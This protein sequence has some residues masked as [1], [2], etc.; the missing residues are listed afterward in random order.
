MPQATDLTIKKANGTTDIVWTLMQPAS[1]D[2]SNAVWRS[3]TVGTSPAVRPMLSVTAK[4]AKSGARH[5]N[6][7]LSY[8]S[9]MQD[10]DG[11]QQIQG[12]NYFNFHASI[13]PSALDSDSAEMAAQAANLL[14]TTLLK[15]VVA[16]G[17]APT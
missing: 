17:F 7:T 4:A 16:A 3:N 13:A 11:I 14:A 12:V 10:A 8:P 2:D 15:A 6:G 5:V 1:G 9:Y